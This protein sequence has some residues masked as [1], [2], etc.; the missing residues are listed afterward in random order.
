MPVNPVSPEEAVEEL[1]RTTLGAIESGLMVRRHT[2][3]RP[4]LSAVH[5]TGQLALAPD[6]P[7]T[8]SSA[9]TAADTFI[10]ELFARHQGEIYAYLYRMVRDPRWPPT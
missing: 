9:R 8:G 5:P 10:E 2:G 7:M 3:H 6:R 4:R 1:Q